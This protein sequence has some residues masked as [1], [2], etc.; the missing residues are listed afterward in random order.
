MDVLTQFSTSSE[1]TSQA[2]EGA[3][4]WFQQATESATKL[5]QSGAFVHLMQGLLKNY[6]EFLAELGQS[7]MTMMSQG[8]AT[9]L[10]Q[11]QEATAGVIEAAELRARR[12]RQSA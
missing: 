9:L 1:V 6:T 2:T 5:M 11:T 4:H 7:T 8:Q 10:R 12:P 3:G